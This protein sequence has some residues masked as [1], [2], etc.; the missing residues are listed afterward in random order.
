MSESELL[1]GIQITQVDEDLHRVLLPLP[2]RLNGVNCYIGKSDDGY[3][4]VDSGLNFRAD[5]IWT[6]VFGQLAIHPSD[7]IRVVITHF[8]PDHVGGA[9]VLELMTGAPVFASTVTIEQSDPVWG[10]GRVQRFAEIQQSLLDNGMPD[11]RVQLLESEQDLLSFAVHLPS[12]WTALDDGESVNVDGSMWSVVATPGHADGHICLYDPERH[13]L[14][15]GDHLLQY[16]SPAVGLFPGNSHNPLKS[17]IE[18]LQRVAAL[19]IDTVFPGHGDPFSFAHERCN[20][21][22]VHHEERL[23]ECVVCVRASDPRDGG[24]SAHA[25]AMEV[26]GDHHDAT[27]ERFALTETIAHLELARSFGTVERVT[28]GASVRYTAR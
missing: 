28:V 24:I 5:L 4:I 17:Y 3:T 6:Y 13:R 22:V 18:S 2:F 27:N 10:S 8:H 21:L 9:R 11:A 1:E 16:I 20:E 25:V 7:V 15:S 19:D 12:A 23:A 14:L 26:F